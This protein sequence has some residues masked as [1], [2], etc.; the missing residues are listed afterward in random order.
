MT[1]SV[2]VVDDHAGMRARI[3][4]LVNEVIPGSVFAAVAT[5]S[6][7]CEVVRGVSFHLALVDLQLPDRSGLAVIHAILATRAPTRIV[8]VSAMPPQSYEA[9]A[10]RAGAHAFLAKEDLDAQL[11]ALLREQYNLSDVSR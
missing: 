6:D 9:L 11:P 4:E 8:A 2:L 3:R 1:Y 10:L 5:A 7:A